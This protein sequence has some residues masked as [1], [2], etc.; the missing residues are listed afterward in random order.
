MT[1]FSSVMAALVR[2][3]QVSIQGS[4]CLSMAGVPACSRKVLA[5]FWISWKMAIISSQSLAVT[6]SAVSLERKAESASLMSADSPF[7][8]VAP[9]PYM[10]FMWPDRSCRALE[11]S[12]GIAELWSI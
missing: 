1:A 12:V 4:I 6:V 10:R 7:S 2:S 8:H 5:S 3:S 9:P 11:P